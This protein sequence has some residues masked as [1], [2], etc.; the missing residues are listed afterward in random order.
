[1]AMEQVTAT[2][3][4]LA[5]GGDYNPE[6][7]PEP[8]W[9]DDVA[10]M[11][12]A[13]VN[14]VTVGVFSWAR[15]EPKPGHF[16]FGWLD[17]ILDLLHENGIAVDLA[18][19]TASP[20]PWFSLAHP[21]AALVD[22]DGVRRY[23]GARQAYCPSAPAFRA[24]ATAL[25]RTLVE[26]YAQHPA[27][28]MWHVSNEYACHNHHCYCDASASAFRDWLQVRYGDLEELNRA[29]GTAFW[30]QHYSAW[31]QVLPPRA[32]SYRSFANPS[33]QLDWWRFSSGEHLRL[34]TAEAEILRAASD[35][36]VT[37][38]FMS[39][40]KP[41]DY[42]EWAGHVDLVSNDDYLIGADPV[43]EQR[44]ALSADLMRSLAAGAPW[45]LMEHSTSAVNWQPRNL[46]KAPGQLRRNSLQHIARGADGALF[47]QWRASRAGA[48]KFHSALLPHAGTDS[49]V[50]REVVEF[51]AELRRLA[52]V[53]G[54]RT[55]P[56]RVAI[57]LDWPAWWA[58]EL[59][60]HP[61]ADLSV[62]AHIRRWYGQFWD[63]NVAV[64]FVHP[65]AD[66]AGYRLVV[67]PMLY[68]VNDQDAQAIARYVEQ[69]GAV[70][71]TY[72]S[73]IVEQNDHVRL[74]GYPGAFRELLG[75]RVEEFAPL[76]P[77]DRVSLSD[78]ST[79]TRWSECGRSTTAEV[80]ARFTSG[81]AA[82]SPALTVN[83]HGSGRAWYVATELDQ[84]GLAALVDALLTERG[85]APTIEGL[86]AGVEAVRREHDERSWLFVLNHTDVGVDVPVTGHDVLADAAVHGALT[87]GPGS[88]AVVLETGLA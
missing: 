74:G 87:V 65:A 88:V 56:A 10:L 14:L 61:S 82:G 29:W 55:V 3:G 43:P 39:L 80:L 32:V 6:Q 52:P 31:E 67:V 45:L 59:D 16:D 35:H 53:A 49:R 41:L 38:N 11:R 85:I 34:F 19:A 20:P 21:E 1:M 57:V 18:T 30:S 12:A 66:L 22:V 17:R 58:A 51:G 78:G 15:L 9:A 84:P 71:V 60:S 77:D 72:F 44:L 27:V 79:G 7:W 68:L 62:A 46:A 70:V 48:E 26:R 47:F 36:P 40:F 25:T 81:V 28:V 76:L 24:A 2:L 42:W 23:H 8:V 63:R 13:N 37:T 86:P 54:S 64:D 33:Q 5:Y 69:G 75:V 4:G 73:G 50:W 83:E